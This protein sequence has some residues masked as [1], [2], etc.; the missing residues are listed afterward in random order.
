M[1][2]N[3]PVFKFT[4]PE[5]TT[6]SEYLRVFKTQEDKDNVGGETPVN[7]IMNQTGNIYYAT[8]SEIMQERT[9]KLFDCVTV[10]FAAMTRAL[11]L[12]DKTLFDYESWEKMISRTG[13]FVQIQ[14]FSNTLTIKS[15]SLSVDTQ[16]VQNLLPGLTEGGRS[17]QIAK[18]V[19]SALSG[20]FT[21][22]QE[23]DKAKIAHILFICE[24]LFGAP[25]VTVRLFYATKESHKKVTSSPCHKSVQ[26]SFEQ[27]QE[28]STFLFVDPVAIAEYGVILNQEPEEYSKL[29]DKLKSFLQ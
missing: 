18:D 5:K 29:I 11:A 10:L 28:A 9:K 3:S 26:T 20:E 25:S 6:L 8:T 21:R 17:M 13:F 19:L 27:S 7:F 22:T 15:G 16:I 1:K 12:S 24:E 4:L 14:K 2:K 23:D